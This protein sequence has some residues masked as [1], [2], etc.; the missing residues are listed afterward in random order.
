MLYTFYSISFQMPYN[1]TLFMIPTFNR[2]KF[3]VLKQLY[4][5]DHSKR[6]KVVTDI[7]M[8]NFFEGD[9]KY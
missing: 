2:F 5:L 7:L 1:N 4:C 3:I 9:S 8:D 6:V